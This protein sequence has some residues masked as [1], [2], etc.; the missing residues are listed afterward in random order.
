MLTPGG[1]NP[2]DVSNAQTAVRVIELVRDLGDC[3]DS[4]QVLLT[5]GRHYRQLFGDFNV[6]ALLM[7]I[8]QTG[9][10]MSLVLESPY[11]PSWGGVAHH[12]LPKET[13][14]DEI[15]KRMGRDV[16]DRIVNDPVLAPRLIGSVQPFWCCDNLVAVRLTAILGCPSRSFMVIPW[17]RPK[18]PAG[19]LM[20]GYSESRVIGDD[21]LDLFNTVGQVTARLSMYPALVNYIDRT[22]KINQSLRR[23]LV[24]DLKTPLTVIKGYAETL[25][26]AE[27]V[28]DVEMRDEFL[29]AIVESCTRLIEDLKEILETV[30]SAYRPVYGEFNLSHLIQRVVMAERHTDRSKHHELELEGTDKPLMVEADQRKIRRV[31][32][33]LLSNAVKYSPGTGKVVT[34]RLTNDETTFRVEIQDQGIGMTEDQLARVMNDAGRVVDDGLGIEGSGFGLDSARKVVEAHNG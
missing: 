29:G 22:E 33:N 6:A 25:E 10:W 1:R 7:E 27:V 9:H 26:H 14:L 18:D 32:E 15:V 13:D 23:N 5:A 20:L 34:V 17:R 21:A 8:G 31:L 30:S 16:S 2:N 12:Q 24:H 19:W 3:A 11:S 4:K 28:E